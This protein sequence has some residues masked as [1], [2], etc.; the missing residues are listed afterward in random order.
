MLLGCRQTVAVSRYPQEWWAPV[1]NHLAAEWE[2]LPQ[3]AAPPYVILSKRNELGLLSN[4]A[5]TPFTYHAVRYASVEGFW[6]SLKYP[7]DA[8]DPRA[9][10]DDVDWEYTRDEVRQMSGFEAKHAGD[11]A[12]YHMRHMGINWVSFEG[13]R[14]IY[15]TPAKGEHYRLIREVMKQKLQDNDNVRR[16]LLRT[17]E[18]TLLPDHLTS[19]DDP[20]AWRYYEIWMELRTELQVAIL[21]SYR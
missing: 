15:R 4:F 16:V 6:Q 13:R 21:Q 17:G 20:P 12:S 2:I 14:M 19:K 1:P 11:L 10:Q 5:H 9:H 7:E 18:L 3:Q 8:D